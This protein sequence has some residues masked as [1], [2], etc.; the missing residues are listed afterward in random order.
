MDYNFKH[1]LVFSYGKVE[2]FE[3]I[4]FDASDFVIEQDK[5]KWGR[6]TYYGSENTSLSLIHI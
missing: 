2:V 1:Y 3:P 5:D 6:D 4:G